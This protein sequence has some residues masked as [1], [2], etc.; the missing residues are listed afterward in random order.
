MIFIYFTAFIN[1]VLL[2]FNQQPLFLKGKFFLSKFTEYQGGM[3]EYLS[4]YFI[5]FFAYKIW[6][7]LILSLSVTLSVVLTGKILEEFYS[8]K[9]S[10]LLQ[11]IPGFFLIMI[12]KYNSGLA[13][14]DI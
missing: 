12:Q 7:G 13:L 5:Q 1:P 3:I 4:L 10:F 6:G 14:I 8:K 9:T 11:F 2:D